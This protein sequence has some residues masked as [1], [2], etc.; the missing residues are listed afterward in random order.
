MSLLYLALALAQPCV[1]TAP[2][3]TERIEV[4]PPGKWTLVY[5]SHPLRERN[6]SIKRLFILVHGQGR[7]AHDYFKTATAAAFLVG[8]LNDTLVLSPRFASNNGE[9]C[10]DALGEG[11]ISQGCRIDTWR[12]GAPALNAGNATS[13]DAADAMLKL[14][15][16]R[17]NFPNL[18]SIVVA[19]HSAGG[20]FVHRYAAASRVIEELGIP[21]RFVVSNPSSYLYLDGRRPDGNGRFVEFGGKA[22]CANFNCYLY[23]LEKRNGYAASI[24]DGKLR[25]NL[26]RRDV[27]YLLGE[28]DTLPIAGFDSSCAAMAQGPSRLARG[29]SYL[30][31]IRNGFKARHTLVKAPLCG[32]NARCVFTADPA[33]KVV[34]SE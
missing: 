1:E 4:G 16:N 27:I 7:N 26:V 14:A 34:F 24:P 30:N 2:A 11:E 8:A 18:R 3:C 17:A 10:Q 9:L 33:L 13:F 23:G 6:E 32:H 15:A 12:S 31:Y 22:A 5:R 25:E 19:G 20:Q 21:V 28:L 29:E